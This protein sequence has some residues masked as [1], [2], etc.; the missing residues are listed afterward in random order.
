[1]GQDRDGGVAPLYVA[2]FVGTAA[3]GAAMNDLGDVAGTSYPDTGCGPFCLPPLQ[4][5]V[6]RNGARIVLPELPGYTGV[7]VRSINNQG[8]A[9]GF[10]GFPYTQT[11]AVVW[12][13][14][15]NGYQI[16]NL[17]VLPGTTRSEAMA[18]DD[19]GRVVGWSTTNGIPPTA[20]PFV[21]TEAAGMQDLSALGF[22][23][24]VPLAMS[25]GGTVATT[26][27]WYKLGDPGS[28][29]FLPPAPQGFAV[30]SYSTGINDAG[31]QARFLWNT[32]PQNLLYLFRFHHDEGTWQ[33]LSSAPSSPASTYGVGS[34]NA[35][36]DVSATIQG[37]AVVAPGPD[38]LAE[39]LE[40]RVSPA[41]GGADV[42]RAGPMNASGQILARLMIGNS[43]RLVKLT[44][45][46]ACESD[47]IV[48]GALLIRG[49]FVQD[50]SE[51]GNCS[52]E[53]EAYNVAR[54]RVSI[55]DEAGAPLAGVVVHGRFLDDYWTDRVVSGT[56]NASGIVSFNNKG[57]C[58]VGAVAFLVDSATLPPREFDRTTGKVTAF[59]IPN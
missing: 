24:E 9:A 17:G 8:W 53:G 19:Q 46:A 49:K 23:D 15:G 12:K 21:W 13:P 57:P 59:V 16:I 3:F 58:G 56:T 26:S 20:A 29:S 14:S 5:V 41:Y 30:G 6:W 11:R 54:A 18:I 28:V 34:I 47:C 25:P 7:Y 45:A 52:P 37:N 2:D 4:T 42:V 35:A 44:P 1:M 22:P 48:V 32:G 31:D 55:K 40:D 50:P 43:A 10:A 36:R 51:P 27:A 33:M 39:P 38:G